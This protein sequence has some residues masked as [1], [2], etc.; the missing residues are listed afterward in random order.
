MLAITNN[1]SS[2]NANTIHTTCTSLKSD[3]KLTTFVQTVNSPTTK[4]RISSTQN[5]NIYQHGVNFMKLLK[6][7]KTVYKFLMKLITCIISE[8][9]LVCLFN[10]K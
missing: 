8:L 7:F 5:T 10:L 9:Q 6:S 3:V 4:T 2:L 1:V